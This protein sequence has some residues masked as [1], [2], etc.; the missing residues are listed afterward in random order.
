M[1]DGTR[2]RYKTGKKVYRAYR[3]ESASDWRY[4]YTLVPVDGG[5]KRLRVTSEEIRPYT[6]DR[7]EPVQTSRGS[8]KRP[9]GFRN[10][11]EFSGSTRHTYVGPKWVYKVERLGRGALTRNKT[12]AALWLLQEGKK[13]YPELVEE[14]GYAIARQAQSFHDEGVP[15]AECHLLSDGTLM[16]E[17]VRPVWN[18][19]QSNGAD[20][21]TH[22]E[23]KALGY[24][25]PR[26]AGMVDCNQIGYTDKG[27]LVAY[28]L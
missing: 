28:D 14:F 10:F 27:K 6:S 15:V 25:E 13:T 9:K 18:L 3:D 2:V 4:R 22:A 24:Q 20:E 5:R 26:W 1:Q 11:P 8:V 7:V 21:L 23:R 19:N 17:R 12:E 16:M